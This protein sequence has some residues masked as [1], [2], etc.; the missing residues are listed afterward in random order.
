MT[1]KNYRLCVGILDLPE[2]RRLKVIRRQILNRQI[3]C[4]EEKEKVRKFVSDFLQMDVIGAN[5]HW[6]NQK[7]IPATRLA[8]AWM[9]FYSMRCYYLDKV[10]DLNDLLPVFFVI[11]DRLCKEKDTRFLVKGIAQLMADCFEDP[12]RANS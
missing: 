3:L 11:V 4:G 1:L 5:I 2:E 6:P 10:A 9:E 7:T 12:N 8:D